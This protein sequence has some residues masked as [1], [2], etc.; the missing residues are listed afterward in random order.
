MRVN[1][2][3][4]LIS[5]GLCVFSGNFGVRSIVLCKCS[6]NVLIGYIMCVCVYGFCKARFTEDLLSHLTHTW[7][8][9]L[10]DFGE[11]YMQYIYLCVCVYIIYCNYISKLGWVPRHC[12][13]NGV[14]PPL[15]LLFLLCC[16]LPPK[17]G[18]T[19]KVY[20]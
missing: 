19:A 7:S 14:K 8:S 18:E 5:I 9:S 10:R 11:L 3:W 17:L 1:G 13:K 4:K 16:R 2:G 20:R 12:W 6:G 15:F